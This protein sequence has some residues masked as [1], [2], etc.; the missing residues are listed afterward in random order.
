MQQIDEIITSS[1]LNNMELTKILK[2]MLIDTIAMHLAPF[3]LLL[4]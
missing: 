3:I 4:R 2:E 1:I